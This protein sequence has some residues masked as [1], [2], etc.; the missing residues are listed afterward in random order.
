M[1]VL[2]AQSIRSL[3][4]LEPFC[5]RT[6]IE[7]QDNRKLTYG[8]S[9]AGYDVRVDQDIAMWPGHFTLAST[10]ERF[11]MPR[12]V[13]GFV[14]D[15]SS[16]ARRGL[17]VQNTVIECGWTGFLTLEFTNHGTSKLFLKKGYPV[18]QI[19]F[20]WLDVEPERVYSGKYQNQRR[21]PQEAL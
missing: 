20:H 17:A 1:S 19:I 21:G 5:E 10:M 11:E 9:V 8:L 13:I 15:K 3:G 12:S 4:I 6:E 2:S 18:A 14:H 7:T 16:W